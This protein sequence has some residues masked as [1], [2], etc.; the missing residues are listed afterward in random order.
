MLTHHAY[1]TF[2]ALLAGA[3]AALLVGWAARRLARPTTRC[4][5]P[6][7]GAGGGGG[8]AGR[9]RGR[10]SLVTVRRCGYELAGLPAG[11]DGTVRCPECGRGQRAG[12]VRRTR[13]RWGRLAV[14]LAALAGCARA[15]PWVWHGRWAPLLP[16]GALLAWRSGLGAD[17]TH[18]AVRWELAVRYESGA[19]DRAQ[20]DAYVGVLIDDLRD[21]DISWNGTEAMEALSSLGR[22]VRGRL[23]A[24]LDSPDWQQRQL[25]AAVLRRSILPWGGME[26]PVEDAPDRLLAVTVEGLRD[27]DLPRQGAGGRRRAA[28]T[29]VAD[30]REGLWFLWNF[31]DRLGPHL[32][33][34]IAS[35]DPQQRLLAAGLAARARIAALLPAA[36]KELGSHLADNEASGDARFAVR[37]LA[38]AGEGARALVAPLA[39]DADPQRALLARYVLWH[40]DGSDPRLRPGGVLALFPAGDPLVPRVDAWWP[41]EMPEVVGPAPAGR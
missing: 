35:D 23:E 10:L 1:I 28:F 32:G 30:A 9:W 6:A 16:T 25:A 20:A 11:A 33:P 29:N 34:A 39:D 8:G 17:Q 31:R 24:A 5:A 36:V 37:C 41:G 14:V 40:L 21:D 13:V 38:D 22:G 15:T 26:G 7:G 4:V 27:D 18:R 3:A 12:A 19:M 2:W